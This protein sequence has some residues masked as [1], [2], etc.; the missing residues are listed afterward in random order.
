MYESR[1]F[2]WG[3]GTYQVC[4]PSWI[5]VWILFEKICCILN[6]AGVFPIFLELPVGIIPLRHES[7][8]PW[9][10]PPRKLTW[11]WNIP[12][13]KM[14]FQLQL[15]IF[16]L[17]ML[18]SRAVSRRKKKL[19]VGPLQGSSCYPCWCLYGYHH[20]RGASVQPWERHED[21]NFLWGNIFKKKISRLV[22][23]NLR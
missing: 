15:G 7:N 10:V 14:Y 9:A 3:G 19:H 20:Q 5:R 2:V 13:L 17:V 21:G 12:H 1:F 18:V 22:D 23:S 6:V 8:P 4:L 11:Q 16:Q